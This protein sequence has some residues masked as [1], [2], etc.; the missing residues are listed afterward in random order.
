MSSAPTDSDDPLGYID[1]SAFTKIVLDEPESDHLRDFL[2]KAGFALVSSSLLRVETTRAVSLVASAPGARVELD[3]ALDEITL[4]T[5]SE[6]I[7]RRA[8]TIEAPLLRTLDAIHL[9]TALE[10]G[11]GQ[12]IAY[13]RRLADAA[14]PH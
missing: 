7:V 1:S 3:S 12:L 2:S 6:A 4:L 14:R 13:D 11:A 5:V 10:V 8:S 9:A